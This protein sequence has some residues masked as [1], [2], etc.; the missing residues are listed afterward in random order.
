MSVTGT[1][2]A[3]LYQ[4]QQPPAR[5]GI[6]KPMKP[7]GYSDSGADIAYALREKQ[8]PVSTPAIHPQLTIDLDWVFPDTEAGIRHA[9][10]KGAQ[11]LWLNTILYNGHPVEAFLKKGIAAVGQLPRNTDLYDDKW[12]TNKLLQRNNLPIPPAILI[13]KDNLHDYQLNFPFPA[14][15]KPIRGRGSEGV[16]VVYRQTE[17]DEIL[18]EMFSA[19][20]FGSAVYVEKYLP[21]KEVTIT[22]MPPG[23]YVIKGVCQEKINYWSLPPVERFNH[24][25]GVAPYNGTVAVV[26]NSK[27]MEDDVLQS[28]AVITLCKQCE[29]AAALVGARA[30]VRI[31]CRQDEQGRYFLFDLN[32]KPNMTGASRPHRM[33]QDSLS[34]L[35]AR[36]IGWSFPDLLE[37][38]LRQQ[39]RF[40]KV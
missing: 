22:V 16:K 35:A 5:N 25:E 20:K 11:V 10:A 6:L 13:N 37:N 18:D 32:M 15:A 21:G 33:D 3:L 28:Q 23:K 4:A 24:E 8:V 26:N 17:L 29:S 36:R 1:P 30:P 2:V 14:V 19:D 38:M 9:L 27:V 34:A 31:D 40:I 39:W 12:T 7:G